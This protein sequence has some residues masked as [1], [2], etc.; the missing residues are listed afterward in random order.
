MSV[1]PGKA[2]H[3]DWFW[4]HW[5][6]R[7][8]EQL[9]QLANLLHTCSFRTGHSG[10]FLTFY[11]ARGQKRLNWLRLNRTFWT[12]R[13]TNFRKNKNHTKRKVCTLPKQT[14]HYDTSISLS[15]KSTV[16]VCVFQ[17]GRMPDQKRFDAPWWT[18]HRGTVAGGRDAFLVIAPLAPVGVGCTAGTVWEPVAP[19]IHCD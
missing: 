5:Q 16:C 10:K 18:T 15:Q 7:F 9:L 14:D 8:N 12:A 4:S 11:S 19:L 3:S 1:L 2:W 13:K 6:L 17:V